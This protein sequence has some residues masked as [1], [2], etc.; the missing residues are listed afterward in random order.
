MISH[1]LDKFSVP[2]EIDEKGAILYYS[3]NEDTVKE[4][5]K[6][7]MAKFETE[8]Q[9]GLAPRGP[10]FHV[11]HPLFQRHGCRTGRQPAVQPGRS[12]RIGGDRVLHSVPDR[13]PALRMGSR[14]S[15]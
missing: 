3:R 10:G 11:H 8:A 12:D 1:E 13:K 6:K 7:I 9:S 4:I 5:S 14:T 15:V 2:H